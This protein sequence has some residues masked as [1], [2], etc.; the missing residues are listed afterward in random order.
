[1]LDTVLEARRTRESS[2][3][4]RESIM[5][6][7]SKKKITV[8]F[9]PSGLKIVIPPGT[10]LLEAARKAGVYLNSICGGDGYCGK[11][12][13]VIDEGQS[14][15]R[16]TTLLTPEE[17][18]E[19]VVLACQTKVLSD[20]TVTVPK[21]HT[22][23][24]SQILMDTDAHRFSELAGDVRAGVFEFDPLV[25]KHAVEMSAPTV[26]DHTAD[27]ERLYVAIRIVAAS[28]LIV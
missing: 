16:P 2:I 18:R 22:L 17:I 11:C 23:E 7:S 12:K 4:D 5:Q 10:I 21:S 20:M 19:N 26:H 14:E 9:E 8:C 28:A 24:T 25:R 1:M 27:H 6:E 15:S 13:V 3:M